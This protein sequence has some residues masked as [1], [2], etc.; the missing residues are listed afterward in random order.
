MVSRIL[1]KAVLAVAFIV[2]AFS[3]A[4]L[5]VSADGPTISPGSGTVGSVFEFHA[6]GF[7]PGETV[8]LWISTPSGEIQTQGNTTADGSGAVSLTI[9]PTGEWRFGFYLQVAHGM[10]SKY[11]AAIQFEYYSPGRGES[12]PGSRGCNPGTFIAGGF[13]ANEKVAVW[14]S[15]PT[16][17]V[18]GLPNVSA[19]G[20][21]VVNFS[22]TSPT[23]GLT[24]TYDVVAQ[25][26]TSKVIGR[27]VFFWRGSGFGGEGDCGGATITQP[28][29]DSG[30]VQPTPQT[31][32]VLAVPGN[33]AVF[34]GPGVYLG[35]IKETLYLRDCGGIYQPSGNGN[36]YFVVLG[37]QPGEHV[38]VWYEILL[39]Q[40]R[41]NYT[42]L[43]ADQNGNVFMTIDDTTWTKGH[44]HW[45]FEAKSAKYCGHYDPW[46]N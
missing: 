35:G 45:W 4:P 37:F 20:T 29:G 34:K 39:K 10:R 2:L 9:V 7:A 31:G 14:Y 33:I 5:T 6:T 26:Y 42:S 43:V 27:H 24:G 25:G 1:N 46:P 3:A 21:G 13:A 15:D 19:D 12:E 30:S 11:E 23:P 38:N 17:T 22:F 44:Y 16:G 40:G 28:S 18:A 8:A 41:T 36:I 32:T